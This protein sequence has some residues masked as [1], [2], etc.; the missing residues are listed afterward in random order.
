MNNAYLKISEELNGAFQRN[1]GRGYCYIEPPLNPYILVEE[2][3]AKLVEKRPNI[4]ILLF[5]VDWENL[6]K[7]NS[8]KDK[9]KDNLRVV[10]FKYKDTIKQSFDCVISVGLNKHIGTLTMYGEKCKFA[11]FIFTKNELDN[12]FINKI[13]KVVPCI[14][15]SERRNTQQ[16]IIRNSIYSP[17]EEYRCCAYLN[18]D[19]REQYDKYDNYVKD[20]M[21]LFNDFTVIDR[22][23]V[24]DPIRQMSAMDCCIEVAKFNGWDS[25]LDMSVEYNKQLDAIF[26]P[27]AI[28]E[29]VNTIFNI[30][31]LRKKLLTDND[32]KLEI[33]K[34]IIDD[35][36]NK[37]I[38]IV[39]ERGEFCNRVSKYLFDNN[40][41]NVGYHNDLE[42]AYLTDEYGE[43]V[44]YKS[45]EHKGEPKIF[46]SSALSTN[47][48]KLFNAN[49]CNILIIKGT[50]DNSIE[51]K[52]DIL[53]Y[54]T[55]FLNNIFEFKNRFDKIKLPTP[56]TMY[57]IYCENTSE[58]KTM[59]KERENS[60]IAIHN[61]NFTKNMKIDE[62]SG[63]IIL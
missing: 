55:P 29:R 13:K 51:T 1:K 8:F 50:S 26:N 7:T 17:V 31:H 39:C 57:K 2:I 42:D 3:I 38:I 52:A 6:V 15:L 25:H 27:I 28:R 36:P 41:N 23:R 24:G 58:E 46:K 48:L 12:T 43:V 16:N 56:L 5:V 30:T 20:S 40:I 37:R 11:L 62:I 54:T 9:Y 45:G 18:N 34:N 47:N 10:T 22:C 49:Y 35:N 14:D 60:L 33:I 4:K 19:D 61:E 53:I 63:D 32:A 44:C 59:M 21:R